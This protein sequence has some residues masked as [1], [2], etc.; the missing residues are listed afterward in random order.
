[1]I[2]MAHKTIWHKKQRFLWAKGLAICFCAIFL[3]SHN[4]FAVDLTQD[5]SFQ[6]IQ[7][8]QTNFAV[9]SSV[10]SGWSGSLSTRY[11][12]RL[13]EKVNAL[14]IY[15]TGSSY[16]SANYGDFFTFP[17]SVRFSGASSKWNT[18]GIFSFS[19]YDSS[20]GVNC[21]I[22]DVEESTVQM[23][24]GNDSTNTTQEYMMFFTCK[25]LASGASP[26]M[27]LHLEANSG[28]SG[29]SINVFGLTHW[30][31]T[32]D[33]TITE[34]QAIRSAVNSMSTAIQNKLDTTNST[35]NDIK[36]SLDD[37]IDSQEEVNQKEL[38]GTTNIENQD[39][40]DIGSSQNA[41]TTNLVGVLTGFITT[42][43][44]TPASNCLINGDLGNLDIGGVNLCQ[45]KEHF[46][47]LIEFIGFTA[48]FGVVFWAGYHLVK[49]TLSLIDWARSK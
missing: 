20:N 39:P 30:R 4:T 15:G 19:N 8:G 6:N 12:L 45:G 40:S 18:S 49:R 36:I 29:T 31:R 9:N 27:N 13:G 23:H 32:S 3:M 43:A 26:A 47:T 11:T 41:G 16:T 22:I 21:P 44:N 46:N 1:M 34:L 33:S 10:Y 17:V 2:K 5:V 24:N 42:I 25:V 37:L 48:L 38:E 28:G 14:R 7:Y 35:L